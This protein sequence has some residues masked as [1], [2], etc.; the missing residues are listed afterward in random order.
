MSLYE[1]RVIKYIGGS[2]ITRG[3]ELWLKRRRSGRKVSKGWKGFS[4]SGPLVFVKLNRPIG[5]AGI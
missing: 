2:G 3:R 1:K 4:L 5:L